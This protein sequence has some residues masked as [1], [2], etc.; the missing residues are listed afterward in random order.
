MPLPSDSIQVT[1]LLARIEAQEDLTVIDVRSPAEYE[2]AHI[3]GAINIPLEILTAH[4]TTVAAHLG[5]PADGSVVTLMLKD[6]FVDGDRL[7]GIGSY[8]VVVRA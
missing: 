3:R 4:A 6:V 5:D 1:E 7:L 2:N 8:A